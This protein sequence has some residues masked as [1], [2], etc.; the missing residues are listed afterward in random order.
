MYCLDLATKKE[1]LNLSP[2]R[3]GK[4]NSFL[5]SSLAVDN[6]RFSEVVW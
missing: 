3:K 5:N 6:A 1:F 4:Q 2:W